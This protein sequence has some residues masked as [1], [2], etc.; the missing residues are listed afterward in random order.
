M[1]RLDIY[2]MSGR[3]SLLVVTEMGVCGAC[4]LP[5]LDFVNRD[6]FT[7]CMHCAQGGGHGEANA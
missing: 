1:P 4:G 2:P 6:G 5:R 3:A 7:V